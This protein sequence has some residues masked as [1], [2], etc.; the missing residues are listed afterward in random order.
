MQCIIRCITGNA[1]IYAFRPSWERTPGGKDII[2]R[3]AGIQGGFYYE[4]GSTTQHAGSK[5]KQNAWSYNK[6]TV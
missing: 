2:P 5:R 4:Y 6:R 3:K 1:R